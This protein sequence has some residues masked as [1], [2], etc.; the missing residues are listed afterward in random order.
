MPGS[1]A[2]APMTILNE[3]MQLTYEV[4]NLRLLLE[5]SLDDRYLSVDGSRLVK[6]RATI[7]FP[8]SITAGKR[9]RD[10][11]AEVEI[12]VQ[13]APK[14]FSTDPPSVVAVLP[15]ERTY[16][17]AS[18]TDNSVS[19]GGG[20]VSHV[21]N[22]GGGFLRGRKT[23]YVVQDQDIVAVQF[24]ETNPEEKTVSFGWQFRPVLG[25][26]TV[27]SGLRQTFV[28]LSFPVAQNVECL[29]TVVVSTRWRKYDAK[30]G[31]LGES[32]DETPVEEIVIRSLDPR[33]S[34]YQLAW[35]DLGNGQIAV[36][37]SGSIGWFLPGTRVRIG[38]LLLDESNG[39]RVESSTLRYVVPTDLAASRTSFL[40][41]RDGEELEVRHPLNPQPLS[42]PVCNVEPSTKSVEPNC[43]K[44]P[45]CP[46]PPAGRKI[47]ILAP[48]RITPIDAARSRVEVD[49]KKAPDEFPA[50]PL[51]LVV[52]GKTFGLRDA[53]FL[54]AAKGKIVAC[55]PT[56]LLRSARSLAVKRLFWGPEYSDQATIALPDDL[57]VSPP[58][59]ISKSESASTFA[60]SGAGLDSAEIVAPVKSALTRLGSSVATF[61]IP[62][63]K[64]AGLKQV[65]LRQGDG[66]PVMLAMP[67]VGADKPSLKDHEPILVS[68]GQSVTIGGTLLDGLE[69]VQW[70]D[71]ELLFKVA[72]AGESVTVSLPD[73]LTEQPGV[74]SVTFKFADG[75]KVQYG[76][77]I[78]R[79]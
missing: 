4:A 20:V 7:G 25:R 21:I 45:E 36:S 39:L 60:I 64:L 35:E 56:A 67:K 78:A 12:R 53:P 71:K 76:L 40:V 58:V 13:T 75:S 28:Q 17:V 44:C 22:G 10:S 2:P 5:G 15:R 46:K 23:Y 61:E 18:I 38:D 16:N 19:I 27:V 70:G 31:V 74:V 54:S 43:P 24:P 59:L 29:G 6:R 47:E 65:I 11:V 9:H 66:Q 26:A 68:K 73:S 48:V 3:Q 62:N 32:F 72:A 8:I 63:S 69:T 30:R 52:G 14:S 1:F 33:P 79:P 55:I 57:T 42:R 50:N 41:S 49:L 37:L 77:K 51:L 34:G